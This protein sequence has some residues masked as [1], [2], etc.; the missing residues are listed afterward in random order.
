MT[1]SSLVH[2][3][4]M[5]YFWMSKRTILFQKIKI[6]ESRTKKLGSSWWVAETCPCLKCPEAKSGLWPWSSNKCWDKG[7]GPMDKQ[8]H[9]LPPPLFKQGFNRSIKYQNCSVKLTQA[10]CFMCSIR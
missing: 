5:C 7:K 8:V 1:E 2:W 9:L 3:V 10:S 6:T 4:I